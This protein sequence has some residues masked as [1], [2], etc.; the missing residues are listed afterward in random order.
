[1]AEDW[2]PAPDMPA[3]LE[4]K[5]VVDEPSLNPGLL[6]RFRRLLEADPS[7]RLLDLGTG[8]GAMLRRLLGFELQGRPLLCGLDTEPR[9]LELAAG[10]IA[11]EL[12]SRQ[13]RVEP[14]GIPET[15]GVKPRLPAGVKA[16]LPEDV[17]AGAGGA[18]ASAVHRV[19][20]ER[21]GQC[22]EVRL[23]AGDLFAPGALLP[24]EETQFDFVTAHAFLDLLPLSPAI[25]VIRGALRPG[26]VLYATSNYDGTTALLPPYGNEAFEEALL[27]AYDRS[28]EAR[29]VGGARTGGALSGRRL[30]GALD[31]SGFRLAGAGSS[32]WNVLP[33]QGRHGVGQARFLKSILGMI[34]AEGLRAAL[35]P[36]ALR[37]WYR[38][39][40]AAVDAGRLGLV[41]HQLDLLAIRD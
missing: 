5:A 29:R 39:R 21:E 10:H 24:F 28:M 19:R 33:E 16:R 20:G 8:T 4:A 40:I 12:A 23:A 11:E 14:A 9:C 35:D 13:Y 15:G 32:D 27:S 34:A 37:S 3:Y 1:V 7:P 38:E 6:A 17:K 36:G 26:G 22:I 30:Y 25:D 41:V 18:C 2:L 31:R